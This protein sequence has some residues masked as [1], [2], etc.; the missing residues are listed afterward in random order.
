VLGRR[1]LREGDPVRRVVA[2]AGLEQQAD[3]HAREHRGEPD[4]VICVRV[5]GDD[6]IEPLDA[7]RHELGRHLS[8]FGAAVHQ[9]RDAPRRGEQ[10]RVSLADVEEPYGKRARRPGRDR[11][12]PDE[13][14]REAEDRD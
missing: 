6:Q 2:T 12:R 3:G 4:D 1:G 9:D 11:V 5:A 13:E 10:R 14:R 7:E 8:G